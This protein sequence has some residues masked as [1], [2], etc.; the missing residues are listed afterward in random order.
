MPRRSSSSMIPPCS[1]S[2]RSGS[3]DGRTALRACIVNF[4]T[5]LEDFESLL[6]AC[7]D[8]GAELASSA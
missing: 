5:S 1:C 3:H 8:L 4:R 2:S 6:T 7:H